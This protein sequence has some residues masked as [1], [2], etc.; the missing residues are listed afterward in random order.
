MVFITL[1]GIDGTGKTTQLELL[2]LWLREQGFDPLT[3]REPGGT[4]VGEKIR[5]LLLFT[6]DG[7]QTAAAELLLYAA[8]RAE[9]VTT[10][11]KPALDSGRIVIADRFSDSTRAYQVWGRGLEPQWV[12]QVLAGAVGGLRPDL[13]LLFDLSPTV[14]LSRV[15]E[16]DRLEQESLDFFTRV[17]QGYLSLAEKEPDRIKIIA[18]DNKGLG[19]VQILVQQAVGKLLFG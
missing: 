8:A 19:T 16:G 9:L 12:E 1:E 15:S 13:T 5:A 14:A 3:V 11:I 18:T 4:P 10:V 17:R 7:P 2:A 6:E